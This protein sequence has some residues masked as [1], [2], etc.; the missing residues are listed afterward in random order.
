MGRAD[1]KDTEAVETPAEESMSNIGFKCDHC[2]YKAISDFK[3]LKSCVCQPGWPSFFA[4]SETRFLKILASKRVILNFKTKKL[5]FNHFHNKNNK[6]RSYVW[7][8]KVYQMSVFM[9]YEEK[10]NSKLQYT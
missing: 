5:F 1:G 9:I 8:F 4:A 7:L 10:T 3:P 6:I 2:S